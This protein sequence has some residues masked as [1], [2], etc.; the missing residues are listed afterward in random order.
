[1]E[2]LKVEVDITKPNSGSIP[3]NPQNVNHVF[4]PET[5]KG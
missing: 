2:A 5:V 3:E 4:K 1:M